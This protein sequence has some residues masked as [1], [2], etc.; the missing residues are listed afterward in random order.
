MGGFAFGAMPKPGELLPT[1]LQD[2]LR[3]TP[4]QKEQLAAIQKET[5]SKLDKLLTDEQKKQLKE[6]TDGT[7]F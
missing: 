6:M 1:F 2:Q 4:E 5:D 3:L 7:R